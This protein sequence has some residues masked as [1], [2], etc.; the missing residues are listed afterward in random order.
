M[1]EDL[2]LN[3]L[4]DGEHNAIQGS[5]AA[6][7]LNH[8]CD[9][10]PVAVQ[11]VADC[12]FLNHLCDGELMTDCTQVLRL[13][14]KPSMRWRT[15]TKSLICSPCLS[16]PSMRWRTQ[17]TVMG[18]ITNISKPSMRWRTGKVFHIQDSQLSKPSMRWR[19]PF[20]IDRQWVIV[21]IYAMANSTGYP[22]LDFK[23]F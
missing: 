17:I 21:S 12:F 13:I 8:L 20:L 16:K 9:G 4:C 5:A 22:E 1:I 10:E 11:S 14:S 6:Q 15:A 23:I 3:H 19:T 18:F 7:F 2:F